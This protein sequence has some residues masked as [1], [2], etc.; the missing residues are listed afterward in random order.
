MC[1]ASAAATDEERAQMQ[2]VGLFHYGEFINVFKPGSLVMQHAG[3]S[4]TP[5]NNPVLIG[6]VHGA[7]G[8]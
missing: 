6:T 1:V 5:T 7:V 4:T 3:D 2:E 8:E